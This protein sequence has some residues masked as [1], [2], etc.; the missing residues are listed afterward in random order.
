MLVFILCPQK[1]TINEIDVCDTK[2]ASRMMRCFEDSGFKWVDT[3]DGQTE[4]AYTLE[5]R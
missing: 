1:G 3:V 4:M 2:L 5:R